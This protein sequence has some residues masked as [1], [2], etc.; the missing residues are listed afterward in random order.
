MKTTTCPLCSSSAH[1]T[2]RGIWNHPDTDV[3]TCD[4]CE[5]MFLK[6]FMTEAEESAYYADYNKHVKSRGVTRGQ[7]TMQLHEQSKA[8]AKDRHR[9]IKSHFFSGASVLEVGSSTGA[10][11]ELIPDCQRYGVEPSTNNREFSQQFCVSTYA[12][13]ADIKPNQVFDVICMF[14]TLEHI[15]QPVEFLTQCKKHLKPNGK[16]IVEVPNSSE[17][18]LQLFDITEFRE[19][20][21][22]PMHPFVYDDKSL[23]YVFDQIKAKGIEV[24]YYQ[25]YGLDN[26]LNWLTVKKPGS[27]PRYK[28]LFGQLSGYKEALEGQ[29]I[30]DTIIIVGSR[31]ET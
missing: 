30:T 2:K 23:R 17:P 6:P 16:I 22:Q 15:R 10:F 12:N 28:D 29:H 14:H 26:H 4:S 5:V 21:F 18:L 27:N 1:L 11:L 19:F 25:R 13:I 24:I 31:L 8:A 9:V 3:Y 7:S 20:Y